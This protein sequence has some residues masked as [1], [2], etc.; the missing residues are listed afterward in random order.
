M[1][2]ENS[3][4]IISEIEDYAKNVLLPQFK[5]ADKTAEIN[6]ITEISVPPLDD[7]LSEKAAS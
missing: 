6:I 5:T 2:G 7:R 3:R 1:P 4:E